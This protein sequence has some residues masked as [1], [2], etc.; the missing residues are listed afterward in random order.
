MAEPTYDDAFT[1]D[2]DRGAKY[3]LNFSLFGKGEGTSPNRN[4]RILPPIQY[5]PP[6]SF[7]DSDTFFKSVGKPEGENSLRRPQRGD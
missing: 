3:E 6:T 4:G 7:T 2:S 1:Y 5:S